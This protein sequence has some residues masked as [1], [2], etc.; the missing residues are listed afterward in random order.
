M[1]TSLYTEVNDEIPD[2]VVVVDID[3]DAVFI[4]DTTSAENP[5]LPEKEEQK[6]VKALQEIAEPVRLNRV[7]AGDD[8]MWKETRLVLMDSAFSFSL[9]ADQF[10]D[11]NGML[12]RDWYKL[13][14]AFLR[15]FVAMLREY[16]KYVVT[17]NQKKKKTGQSSSNSSSS[18]SSMKFFRH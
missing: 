3:N 9:R 17:K 18:S 10:D 7:G 15:F 8:V 11:D 14:V 4:P 16:K 1:Q 12:E 5:Q 2:N 13:R 6:L